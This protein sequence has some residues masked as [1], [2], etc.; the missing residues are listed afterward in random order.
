MEAMSLLTGL[1]NELGYLK[2]VR[3]YGSVETAR[4][5]QRNLPKI[6]APLRPEGGRIV[7]D[8]LGLSLD[9]K[10][11]GFFLEGMPYVQAI[12]DAGAGRFV[13]LPTGEI[14]FQSGG[15][16]IVPET[17]QELFILDEVFRATV[18]E[19]DGA[20]EWL[21]WDVGANVG[22]S[23]AFF[24]G[25]KG[26]ETVAYEPFPEPFEVAKDN[27]RR[28]GLAERVHL[29]RQGVSD[30]DQTLRLTYNGG[31]R[32]S[33][34]LYGNNAL[35]KAGEDVEV[36]ATFVDA[37]AVVAELVERAG[38][39]PILAKIDC[40]GAEYEIVRRL[41]EAGLLTALDAVVMEYHL[42]APE[43]DY[44]ALV[45]D[46]TESGFVVHGE[47]HSRTHVGMLWAVARG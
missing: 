37:A 31:S 25:V 26:W 41:R 35:D 40:E 44:G 47:R 23:A 7:C 15:V 29:R 36:E 46:F 33:N 45:R 16:R 1:R 30:R 8:A 19:I 21:V 28:S 9:P 38:G 43:H 13:T 17:E 3:G 34:G 22:I 11:H 39:R 24:G 12:V 10:R 32:G 5:I 2:R 42:L 27:L 20:E 4:L 18:Y 14:E 6:V